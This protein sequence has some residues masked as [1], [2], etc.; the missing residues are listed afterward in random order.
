MEPGK[1]GGDQA[2]GTKAEEKIDDKTP[3]QPFVG[4]WLTDFGNSMKLSSRS[5]KYCT[6]LPQKY[7][8]PSRAAESVWESQRFEWTGKVNNFS[9]PLASGNCR[10]LFVWSRIVASRQY[11]M[12]KI[13]H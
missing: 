10:P 6:P 5:E 3:I 13:Q 4:E 7:I 8:Y 2:F 1:E 12:V 9:A 11:R